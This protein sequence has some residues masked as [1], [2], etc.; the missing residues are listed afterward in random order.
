[1][2]NSGEALIPAGI[3]SEQ[4]GI[5]S[6]GVNNGSDWMTDSFMLLPEERVGFK[7]SFQIIEKRRK[8]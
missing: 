1:V 7:A 8:N 6:N 3:T 2:S 4:Q 5:I